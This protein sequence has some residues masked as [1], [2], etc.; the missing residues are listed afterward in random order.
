VTE[1]PKKHPGGRPTDYRPEYCEMVVEDMETGYS[2]AAFAGLIGVA[3]RTITEWCAVHPEFSLA[4]S[5]GKAARLRKWE[6][7]AMQGAYT[8]KGGNATLIIFGLS[9]AGRGAAGE[10]DEWTAKTEVKHSGTVGSYDLTKISDEDLER[11]EAIL[12]G[13]AIAID[14]SSGESGAGGAAPPP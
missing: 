10:E 3:R 14:D 11:L 1:E 6:T 4:V 13:A 12:S 7:A 2:L 5:R 8:Q 9:N